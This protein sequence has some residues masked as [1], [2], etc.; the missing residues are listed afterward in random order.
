MPLNARTRSRLQM[1]VVVVL[2]A[3]V[4]VVVAAKAPAWS[5]AA[6][7]FN[8]FY[9]SGRAWL[10]GRDM[11]LDMPPGAVNNLNLPATTLL[12]APF[13]QLSQTAAFILWTALGLAA[14]ALVVH[15]VSSVR[16]EA[17]PL[18]LTGI[19]LISGA[20]PLAWKLGQMTWIMLALVTIA[21]KADRDGR[22]LLLGTTIGAVVYLKPFL[23]PL[24]LYLLWRREWRAASTA[25]ATFL[26]LVIV[27]FVVGGMQAHVSW[28]SVLQMQNEAQG[29]PLNASIAGLVRRTLSPSPPVLHVTPIVQLGGTTWLIVAAEIALLVALVALLRT[30]L[31]DRDLGWAVILVACLLMSPLG[32]AYYAPLAFGPLVATWP[33]ISRAGQWLVG[34]AGVL[35]CVPAVPP[36]VVLNSFATLTWGSV[37][38]WA[39]LLLF[40]GLTLNRGGTPSGRRLQRS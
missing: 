40:A 6:N 35:L 24:V 5:A 33:R 39:M 8:S 16:P 31:R 7:D 20:S 29:H 38:G 3:E 15:L 21:W 1:A 4:L 37:Y 26:A 18:A 22:P 11:Y 2:L 30:R 25:L 23:A 28:L 32:W 17:S 19:L 14:V 36:D 13:A 9:H 27:G 34:A 12:F 10:E